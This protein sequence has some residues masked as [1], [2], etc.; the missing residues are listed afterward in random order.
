MQRVLQF[1]LLVAALLLASTSF[2][3]EQAIL[4]NGFSIRHERRA[5]F[6]DMTRLYTGPDASSYIDV[7]TAD[8]DHYEI[9]TTPAPK[10][11]AAPA[12]VRGAAPAA[13][14]VAT[15]TPLSAPAKAAMSLDQIV[16]QASD[17]HKIDPD[18]V[19]S[20]IRAE[21]GFNVRAVSPKGARG[22]MQLMPQ[23]ANNL[24]VRNSFDPQA[25]VDGGTRYLRFL[26]EKYN[27]DV[28][29]ALA[30]YNAG[31]KRV[32]QYHG[33]PPYYETQAYV[34]RIIRDYNKKKIAQQKA[35][36]RTKQQQTTTLTSTRT[37]T[38]TR[39][40]SRPLSPAA[41]SASSV[42]AAAR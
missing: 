5:T 22:L 19:N 33:I 24:G 37:K 12:V 35:A 34:A 41:G 27:Y 18:F 16:G 28:V 17:A 14:R 23:T 36:S 15:S 40:S 25:N 38:A 10:P 20:V 4:R 7:P 6:G 21:S 9:D 30:A 3:A 1:G 39:P 2:A 31:P 11:A 29:K 8:I 13:P 32:D 42:A 26:L